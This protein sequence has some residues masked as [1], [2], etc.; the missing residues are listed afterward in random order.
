MIR[1]SL[2]FAALA[3]P[4]FLG[5]GCKD[6]KKAPSTPPQSSA[7][8]RSQA[9]TTTEQKVSRGASRQLEAATKALQEAAA[10]RAKKLDD[11][12]K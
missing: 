4:L 2:L 7:A 5:A 3:A 8:T 1:R 11:I 9:A 12:S 10:R 6:K